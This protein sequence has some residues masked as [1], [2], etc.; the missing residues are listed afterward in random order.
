MI[1]FWRKV[2][3]KGPTECWPWIGA[4]GSKGYGLF[5]SN[6]VLRSAHRAAWE[7]TNGPIP[8]LA[9]S[10]GMCVLHR[11]D[12]RA[13]VNPSH[14]FLGTHRDNMTDMSS[15]GRAKWGGACGESLPNSKLR[16]SDVR[17]I[18]GLLAKGLTTRQVAEQFSLEISHV[19]KI[20]RRESWKHVS[21][22]AH[23]Q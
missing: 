14:L 12:N 15:K 19:G 22:E 8:N 10:H 20:S 16:E 13:C 9:G 3:R 18:L 7:L 17:E 5:R 4:I 23:V 11:C 6:R 1:D 2:D 21:M